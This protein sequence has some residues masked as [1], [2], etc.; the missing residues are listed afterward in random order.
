MLAFL[1]LATALSRRATP[2]FLPIAVWYG[3]GKVRAPM[4]DP[5][6]LAHRDAWQSDLR[7]IKSLG[8]NSVRT[9]V[10][11]ASIEPREGEFH[12]ENVEQLADPAQANG[13]RPIAQGRAAPAP[14]GAD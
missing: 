13:L 10:D 9:W 6:P 8:F 7:Q 3:G 4:L 14:A 11:W 2:D 1:L 12:L 5:D